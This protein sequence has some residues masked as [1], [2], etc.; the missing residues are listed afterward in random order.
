MSPTIG[1]KPGSVD[2]GYGVMNADTARVTYMGSFST[3]T[4][5]TAVGARLGR[6]AGSNATAQVIYYDMA[7]PTSSPSTLF[8][9]SSS[10]TISAYWPDSAGPAGGSNYEWS[11][12]G[13][14]VAAGR[15]L[16]GGVRADT[17]TLSHGQDNS[18]ARMYFDDVATSA[19]NPF[20]EDSDSPQG[21][22]S[23]WMYGVSNRKPNAP[24]IVSP[25]SG[26]TT[27][28]PTPDITISFSDPDEAY[29][30]QFGKYRV[31]LWNDAN[32]TL[33]YTSGVVTTNPTQKSTRRAT[34]TVPS[35]LAAGTYTVR[36]YT[37]DHFGVSSS[38]RI[39][40]FVVNTGGTFEDIAV[41]ALDI[42]GTNAAG[43]HI[44]NSVN[45]DPTGVWVHDS[46]QSTVTVEMRVVNYTTGA[47]VRTA[48][49]VASVV[50]DGGTFNA[51]YQDSGVGGSWAN[52]PRGSTIYAFE[53]RAEDA[54]GSWSDW[55]RGAPFMV[56]AYPVVAY[57]SPT[58]ADDAYTSEYPT[59]TLTV[60]DDTD[61]LGSHTAEFLNSTDGV[62]FTY[63]P[64]VNVG[65]GMYQIV[66][67]A[68]QFPAL[69]TYEWSTRIEDAYG[70]VTATSTRALNLVSPAVVTITAPTGTITTGTPTVTATV[71]RTVSQYRVVVTDDATG[72]TT[73]DSGVQTGSG[74]SVSHA[75]PAATLYNETD[76]TLGLWV[77]TSDTLETTE[78]GTFRVEYVAPAAMTNVALDTV[79]SSDFDLGVMPQE[80]NVEMTWD[81]V[82]VATVP[83]AEWVGYLVT[84]TSADGEVV[85]WE[86]ADRYQP[87]MTDTTPAGGVEYTYTVQYQQV[88]NDVDVVRSEPVNLTATVEIA[89][90][91]ITSE[92][93]DDPAVTLHFWEDRGVSL[94]IGVEEV[95]LLGQATPETWHSRVD[96]DRI[97]GTFTPISDTSGNG[98]YSARQVVDA[99]RTLARPITDEN[100]RVVPRSL[101]YRD[102]KGRNLRVVIMAVEETDHH[103]YDRATFSIDMLEVAS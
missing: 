77:K 54:L 47:V 4:W 69:D 65:G 62:S 58:P 88:I 100:G 76:Y 41:R 35:T 53:L 5:V 30:D 14:P 27:I 56:N 81:I 42:A 90:V 40:K 12:T 102:P 61:A 57:E 23:V 96:Y 67:T 7:G 34:Y 66:T 43:V 83:D 51:P 39:W 37:Y 44:T 28:D 10:K 31:E 38:A 2:S 84:R 29:G 36:A 15:K 68:A 71:D 63:Y 46:G 32:D 98:F 13:L 22:M 48:A 93:P 8:Y 85:Q 55:E 16:G 91:T 78:A 74:S 73:Y 95:E 86:I 79:A 1:R 24:G 20:N 103:L 101:T 21:K 45:P 99:V 3:A 19:P 52:L 49:A 18:G 97:S 59:I 50:A 72:A 89:H 87:G 80:P 33:L 70:L 26:A 75:I 94:N 9:A 60:V 6:Y 25:S 64:M 82:E 17:A 11:V 92:N